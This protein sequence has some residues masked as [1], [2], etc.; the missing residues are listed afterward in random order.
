MLYYTTITGNCSDLGSWPS[1]PSICR[2]TESAPGPPF[3]NRVPHR[4]IHESEE[5]W[6]WSSGAP[7]FPAHAAHIQISSLLKAKTKHLSI[8]KLQSNDTLIRP[9]IHQLTLAW[10]WILVNITPP[11]RDVTAGI[12]AAT[13]V[14]ILAASAPCFVLHLVKGFAWKHAISCYVFIP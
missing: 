2:K 10:R 4:T 14:H 12:V 6:W 5:R 8:V 7:H 11:T 9:F 13:R 1:S 3:P